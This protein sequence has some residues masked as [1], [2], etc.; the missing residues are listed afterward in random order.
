MLNKYVKRL[1]NRQ[2]SPWEVVRTIPTGCKHFATFDA[3]KGYHKVELD[4]ES[5]K[6]TMF[7]TPFGMYR[8]VRLAMGLSS[9]GDVFTTWYGDV[10]DYTAEG[11]RCTEDTLLHGHTSDELA[12]K[13]RDF[14]SACSEAGIT[15]NVKKIMYDKTEVIFGGYLI[16]ESGYSIDPTL[17]T[18]QSEFPVPKSQTDI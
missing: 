7:H 4:L 15:L 5:R 17:S 10:I 13:T 6:L 16:N 8:Y 14:I 1:E 9:A 18:A 2:R 3:F 11:R 12:K